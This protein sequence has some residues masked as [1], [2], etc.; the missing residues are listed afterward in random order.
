MCEVRKVKSEAIFSVIKELL[1]QG[2][3]ARIIV[4]G[5]S[6][7]PF[8]RENMDSVELSPARFDSLHK[9]SIVLI[10][11]KNGEYVL[12]RVLRKKKECFFMAGD[13]QQWIEGPIYPEQLIAVA[14]VVWRGERKIDCTD[15]RW[16][17]LSCLWM[18]LLPVRR[19]MIHGYWRIRPLLKLKKISAQG[20]NT[21]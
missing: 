15:I 2:R 19:L 3:S 7:Y 17:L 6:M 12:H 13:A 14:T 1:D 21:T 9:G 18:R 8:L 20:G 16:R 10:R 5:T 4:T 11:R